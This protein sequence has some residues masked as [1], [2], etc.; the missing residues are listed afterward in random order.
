M[1]RN[2]LKLA[3]IIS[4]LECIHYRT[5]IPKRLHRETNLLF[6]DKLKD[7]ILLSL[8]NFGT[9]L[10]SCQNYEGL[11][12]AFR[13]FEADCG[14]SHL[15]ELQIESWLILYS[16]RKHQN[17]SELLHSIDRYWELLHDSSYLNNVDD[18]TKNMIISFAYKGGDDS[19]LLPEELLHMYR[20]FFK[21]Y[22]THLQR[23]KENYI[24]PIIRNTWII[25]FVNHSVR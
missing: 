17:D 13:V 18:Y 20:Q 6:Y 2:N 7:Q 10:N 22:S 15:N 19:C 4:I 23:F 8:D 24:L 12:R 16:L 14:F 25:N 21:E 11:E 1:L 3:W 5:R 9:T